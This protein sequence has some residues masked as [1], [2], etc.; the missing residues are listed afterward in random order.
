MFKKKQVKEPVAAIK[1][2]PVVLVTT[3]NYRIVKKQETLTTWEYKG[4][5]I[6]TSY[7]DILALEVKN[8]NAMEEPF[9]K[10]SQILVNANDSWVNTNNFGQQ[11]LIKFLNEL[12]L[13]K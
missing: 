8:T 12:Y 1:N 4:K 7:Y 6:P 10:T 9:W 11:E 2:P 3:P 13:G 5:Y